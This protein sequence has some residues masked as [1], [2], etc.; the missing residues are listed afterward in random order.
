M[1][2]DY[3]PAV[4]TE[5]SFSRLVSLACH[6]L[7]TPL[8]TVHGFARTLERLE[9]LPERTLKYL[10]MIADASAEMTDQLEILALVA[11]IERGAYQPALREA[12]SLEL[13]RA[14]ATR[15]RFGG[16]V[17]SGAG[18]AVCVEPERVEWA[19]AAFAECA[20]RH[21]DA[22][23]VSLDVAGPD[24][25][26]SPVAPAGPILLGDDLRDVGAA[27]AR[28]LVEALGGSVG[29]EDDGFVVRL[30]A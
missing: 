13:T 3:S 17:A 30:P 1:A 29:L 11:R 20:L 10:G 14:A 8:A 5:P 12:D 25:R 27:S 28:A 22:A 4:Q 7:R 23:S 26:L 18:A 2:E 21:G 19:L 24:V 15:V 9:P 6:D 16:A